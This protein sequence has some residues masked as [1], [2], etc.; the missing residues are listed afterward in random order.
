MAS[1]RESLPPVISELKS[2]QLNRWRSSFRVSRPLES[3]NVGALRFDEFSTLHG[4]WFVQDFTQLLGQHD[5]NGASVTGVHRDGKGTGVAIVAV[6]R[7]VSFPDA[8]GVARWMIVV[9]DEKNL[10]PEILIERVLGFNGGQV[11]AGGDD[12]TIEDDKIAFAW[13]KENRL[14]GPTTQSDASEQDGGVIGNL[15]ERGEI[16]E[17]DSVIAIYCY[18]SFYR[19]GPVRCEA[20]FFVGASKLR[21]E[22]ERVALPDQRREA[23]LW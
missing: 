21:K 2:T 6:N 20:L 14:L 18:Y 5:G 8:I 19:T 15:G 23:R 16:H 13:G 11:V 1:P 4:E 3:V 17:S 10:G 12:A 7:P 22:R 9:S